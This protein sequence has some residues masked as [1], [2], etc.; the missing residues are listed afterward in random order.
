M[1]LREGLAVFQRTQKG[2]ICVEGASLVQGWYRFCPS[3]R[4]FSLGFTDFPLST[5]FDCVENLGLG[6]WYCIGS[7]MYDP[8]SSNVKARRLSIKLDAN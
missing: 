6:C 2:K 5:V 4:G 1:D 8:G 3:L 7:T